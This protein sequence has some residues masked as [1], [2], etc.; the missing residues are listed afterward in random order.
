MPVDAYTFPLA[1]R[2]TRPPHNVLPPEV[3]AQ[4]VPL[5]EA[6][7][8]SGVAADGLL[9]RPSFDDV[10]AASADGSGAAGTDWLRR[11]PVA[12]AEHVIVRWDSSLSIRTTWKVFT[13]HWADFCYPG[14]D[15][16]EVV[17]QSDEWLL[18]YHH[19]EQFEWG[20]RRRA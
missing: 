14:S 16:V 20:R 5:P 13:D 3:M 9:D 12:P 4:I 15:D 10:Q 11:L 6:T 7:A 8:P 2:W 1:W 19:W 18:L 17:P